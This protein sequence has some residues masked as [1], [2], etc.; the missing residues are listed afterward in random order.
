ASM[1]EARGQ[2][3]GRLMPVYMRIERMFDADLGMSRS[4]TVGSFFNT[5]LEQAMEQGLEIDIER[6]RALLDTVKAA[7]TREESGPRYDRHDF[8]YQPAD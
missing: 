3:D 6:A 4:E 7:A 8:W 2:G 1:R 5:A